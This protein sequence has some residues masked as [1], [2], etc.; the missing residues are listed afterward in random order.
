[1]NNDRVDCEQ[2][3]LSAVFGKHER[4][5]NVFKFLGLKNKTSHFRAAKARYRAVSHVACSPKQL[6]R[7]CA[8]KICFQCQSMFSF[9]T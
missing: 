6:A 4:T 1:M 5:D 9:I 3:N 7:T 2:R 8:P